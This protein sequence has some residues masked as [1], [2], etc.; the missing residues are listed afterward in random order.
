MKYFYW[1]LLIVLGIVMVY[2]P[3]INFVIPSLSI[4]VIVVILGIYGLARSLFYS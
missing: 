2:T 1:T 4:G 3:R